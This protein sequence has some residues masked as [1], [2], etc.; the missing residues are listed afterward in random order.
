[1][2]RILQFGN[3]IAGRRTIHEGLGGIDEGSETGEPNRIM[4]PQTLRV[5]ARNAVESVEA[6]PMGVAGPIAQLLQLAEHRERDLGT[7]K[8]GKVAVFLDRSRRNRGS[9]EKKGSLIML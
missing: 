5:E 7:C 6:A 9:A 4:G 8:S 3:E 1:V 2:E